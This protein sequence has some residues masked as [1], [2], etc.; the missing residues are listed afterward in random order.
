MKPMKANSSQ[1]TSPRRGDLSGSGPACLRLP[2]AVLAAALAWSAVAASSAQDGPAAP[3]DP[4]PPGRPADVL[5][6]APVPGP[7]VEETYLGVVVEPVDGVLRSQLALPDGAGLAV[8]HVEPGSPAES[9]PLRPNDVLVR[10]GDQL[11]VTPDQLKV[12]VG[13]RK[14]GEKA[15]FTLLRGGKEQTIDVQLGTRRRV[16]AGITGLDPFLNIEEHV[17]EQVPAEVAQALE[18]AQ[19]QLGRAS[20]L[21]LPVAPPAPPQP[22]PPGAEWT[23]LDEK[24]ETM[25]RTLVRR[26]ESVV[27][28]DNGM[29]VRV[30]TNDGVGRIIVTDAEGKVVLDQSFDSPNSGAGVGASTSSSSSSIT[31][32]SRSI[33][34]SDAAERDTGGEGRP[35]E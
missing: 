14:S 5:V 34:E 9:A 4:G 2:G 30:Q 25:Q 22:R 27:T 1:P 24:R 28:I 31:I 8:R 11:L 26:G 23:P 29:T 15:S 35:P 18:Q 13:V 12:L 32:E 7:E 10:M 21:R 3:P 16:D 20:R 19:K 33:D 17:I 6:P